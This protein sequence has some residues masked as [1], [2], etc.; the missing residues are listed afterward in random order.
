[1]CLFN[2]QKLKDINI[3]SPTTTNVTAEPGLFAVGHSEFRRYAW[4]TI[5]VDCRSRTFSYNFQLTFGIIDS[6]SD[7]LD[8]GIEAGG[9]VYPIIAAWK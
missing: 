9:T 4:G 2:D 3:Y 8:I 7:P 5:N 1:M 6:F